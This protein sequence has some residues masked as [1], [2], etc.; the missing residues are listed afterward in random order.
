MR[1]L[2]INVED[3]IYDKFK[4]YL[5]SLSNDIEIL[6]DKTGNDSN[7]EPILE[8]DR[9]LNEVVVDFKGRYILQEILYKKGYFL[10]RENENLGRNRKIDMFANGSADFCRRGTLE[11]CAH[12]I[13]SRGI[14]GDVAELGVYKGDFAAKLNALFNKK[15]YLFDTFDGFDDNDILMDKNF[16]N[17]SKQRFIDTSE[18]LV[19]E[20]MPFKERVVIRKGYFPKTLSE[21]DF[22]KKFSFVSLDTDLFKPIYDGL[23]FFYPRLSKGGYIFIHDYNNTEYGGCKEAINKFIKEYGISIVP[24]NDGWGTAII[25][26]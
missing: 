26:K 4:C 7:D 9:I 23:V 5:N 10:T 25:S 2:T 1:T 12:E 24:M 21:D 13:N 11:L 19:L 16:S 18:D 6:I 3:S 17:A 22:N 8:Q 14:E 20:K 15:L